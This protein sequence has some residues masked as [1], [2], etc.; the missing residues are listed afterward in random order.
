MTATGAEPIRLYELVLENGCCMSPYVWRVK[1]ALAHKGLTSES[2]AVGFTEIPKVLDGRFKT[3]PVIQDGGETVGDSW[4]IADYLDRAYLERPLFSSPQERSMVRFFDSWFSASVMPPMFGMFALD[5]HD[6]A[7]PEDRGYFRQ[8]REV[9]L[10]GRTLEAFTADREA[11]VPALRTALRP[12]RTTLA[13]TPFLGGESP[14]YADYIALGG[15]LWAAAVGSLAPLAA[16][17]PLNAWLDRGRGL[18]GGLGQ[19]ER[20][21]PLAA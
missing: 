7:R 12:L 8:S 3:V 20:L 9:Q 18:Y 14:N 6:S 1:Y 21:K 13:Q 4:A 19:D 2:I 16:D 11:K 17:D 10:G 15:F 5:I